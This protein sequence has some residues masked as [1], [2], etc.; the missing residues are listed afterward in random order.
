MIR[1]SYFAVPKNIRI[2]STH[3]L[4]M[5]LPNKSE[6]QQFVFNHSSDFMT[7]LRL[8]E[9]LQKMYCKTIYVLVVD[10]TL[11]LD[12]A[13]CFRKNLLEKT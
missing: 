11:A 8:H 4:I 9:S 5:K 12:N 6:L 1:Q 7:F 2:N 3:H 10:T 13:L